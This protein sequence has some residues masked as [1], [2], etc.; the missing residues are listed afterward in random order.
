MT[1]WAGLINVLLCT[2][3]VNKHLARVRFGR[4]PLPAIGSG[5][6]SL[7]DLIVTRS[8]KV[9]A[10]GSNP[11]PRQKRQKRNPPGVG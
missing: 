5:T 10:Q 7:F 2:S 11:P 4:C 8:D 3:P 6:S 9:V 1:L